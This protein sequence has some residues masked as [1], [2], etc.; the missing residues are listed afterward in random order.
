MRKCYLTLLLALIG[1]NGFSQSLYDINTIQDIR[2]VFAQSN[3]D[4]LLD[5][6]AA[7][8]EEYIPAQSV[9]INGTVFNNVGVKYKGNSTYNANRVKNPFHI[10]LDTYQ[11]QDYQGY[12]DI[13]LS[14]VYFDP[15]FLREPLSYSILR[16]YMHAPLSN[17]ANVY[18]NGTLIGLYVSSESI[19]KKFVDEHFYSNNNA[20][21]K[22]NPIGGAGPGS[23]SYPNLAY[24]GTN[25]TSYQA[26]YEM[27][28]DAG[29]EDLIALTNTLAND[30]SNIESILDVDRALWMLA[31]DNVLVNLDSYIGTFKQNYYLYK[32]DNG[33]FNAI[34]WD[35]NMSFGVFT[36]TGTIALNT[37]TAKK[38]M[39]HLLHSGDAAWPLMQKLMAVPKYKRMYLAHIRTILE[40]NFA[41]N[42]YLTTAQ[43]YQNVIDAA[44]QA[45]PNKQYTY[46][47][48]QS[49]LTTDMT[50]GMNAAPG[51]TNLMS[52]RTTYLLSQT[53]FTNTRPTIST[54]APAVENPLI[55]ND[56]FITANVTDA[57]SNGVFLGY[58]SDKRL[59]F[60]KIQM[61]DDG[62]HGDGAA[63][64]LI[65]GVAMNVSN[66]F[67]QYYI[68]AENNNV[69]R[70]SPERAEHEFY[71]LYASYPT[72]NPG[73]LVVNEIMAQNTETV[74]D[75]DGEYEDW[76]EL[77]NNTDTTLSLDNLFMT[78]T[79]TNLV[80][81]Q[82]PAGLTIE[83]HGYLTLWAD[84]D[85]TQAGIHANF[86]LS[87]SGESVILSYANGTIIETVDFGAQTANMGYARVPNGTGSFVIQSPTFNVNNELL[88]VSSAEFKKNLS[89]F[90][91][92]TN[93]S[94]NLQNKY[95]IEKLELYNLQG[96]LLFTNEYSGQ[97]QIAL[98]LSSYSKGVYMLVVNKNNTL[99]IVKN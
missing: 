54:V 11:D 8:T 68:Y 52:G 10:E 89:V 67:M 39:T 24:L 13:K 93:G 92:P 2:I 25:S 30:I 12:T 63:G 28:S 17:Y 44:V 57:N 37:T 50:G 23:S 94:L 80:K 88:S 40:E 73:D 90:P 59:P 47:Q 70:F 85:G 82:F 41:N 3:W 51:I 77:Y 35:L 98:D 36:Q 14:N 74:T 56:V 99:K 65:F 5:A 75:Q 61:Y 87:A 76:I 69:G 33:R 49:N 42:S 45:D 96:Q 7:S 21:F 6:Q 43:S 81:W 60:T 27:N 66:A 15:T 97:N 62:L 86:K 58:R 95:P 31:F 38:Q 84:E 29:W 72:I 9:T 46:A 22:C 83:P 71:T 64:D 4:A 20:F 53:D 19:S 16:Q 26:A 78:D 1:C 34:V 32:D 79:N 55:N 91:N 48:F 18:V